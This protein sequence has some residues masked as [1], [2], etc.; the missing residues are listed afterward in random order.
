MEDGT[1]GINEMLTLIR[2]ENR[3][4]RDRMEKRYEE[5]NETLKE[6]IDK[7]MRETDEK[8]ED[9]ARLS[10]TNSEQIAHMQKQI[11]M[12]MGRSENVEKISTLNHK[13][14]LIQEVEEA[15]RSITIYGFSDQVNSVEIRKWLIDTLSPSED[16]QRRINI[17]HCNKKMVTV[18]FGGLMVLS[19]LYSI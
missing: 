15:A 10:R 5:G 1:I 16:L 14:K 18:T 3:E 6:A 2:N 4:G 19:N 17:T 7:R 9:I 8:V 11:D 12:L 13:A